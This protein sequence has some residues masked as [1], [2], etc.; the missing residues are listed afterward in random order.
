[1]NPNNLAFL[2][3]LISWI[4]G[5]YCVYKDYEGQGFSWRTVADN[6]I[7]VSLIIP[8]IFWFFVVL[9]AIIY[10]I[11]GMAKLTCVVEN[12]GKNK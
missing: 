6:F 5:I 8:A 3:F 11:M 12:V 1:M 2:Y 7:Y 9:G 4:F 10:I